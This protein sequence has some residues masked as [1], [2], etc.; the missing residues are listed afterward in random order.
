MHTLTILQGTTKY[1]VSFE[2]TPTVQQVLEANG[3]TMPH[4]C[5]GAGRCGKCEIEIIGAVSAPDEKEL[6]FDCRLSCRTR[7]YGDAT[8]ILHTDTNL[9]TESSTENISKATVSIDAAAKLGAAVDIGTTT[10]A[11]SVYDLA[12]GI[13]LASETMLNPQ[14]TVAADVIGRID[15]AAKGRLTELQNMVLSCIKTLAGRTGYIDRIDKWCITGNTTMLY[16]LQGENP[17]KLAVSP[18]VAEHL[19]GEEVPFFKKTAYLPDCMHAFVGADITCAVLASGMCDKAETALLCDVGT[20]GEIA[21]RKNEKLYTTSTAAGPVFEGAGISHGC[22][23]ITGAIETVRLKENSLSVKTIGNAKAVGLCGSGVIDTV[24]CLL[25]NGTIDETGAMEEDEILLCENVS[26]TQG[27][28]RNVQLAKAAIAAGIRTLLELTNTGAEEIST[29][30]L[31][32]GF[33]THL[34]L[35]SAVR[36]GLFPAEFRN[37]VKILGNAAL[38][39][40]ASMLTDRELK[41]KAH[42]IARNAECINLGGNPVFN[43][44]YID[45]MYFP[46]QT[47][48][49]LL[50][51]LA[52]EIEFSHIG[53]FDVAKLVFRQEVRDMCKAGRCGAYGTRWTCPPYCGALEES[54]EKAKKFSHGILLQMTG[55]MEDDF[56]VECMQETERLLK[57]RLALFAKSLKNRTISCLPMTAGTCTKCKTCTCPDAPCR[58]PEEAY[59]SM[60]AYGLIVNDVCALADVKYNYGP[61]TITFTA[62]VLFNEN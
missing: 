33:G 14:S 39:G 32:G 41:E 16:L 62:C 51:R 47:T 36:I 57:E 61:K 4:P 7:L 45:E 10:V 37:K 26:F 8:V 15:A 22:Q 13:C 20:N 58:F 52:S 31:A 53:F 5:G 3:I 11:L 40:A 24:S 54:V 42:T 46:E 9:V 17:E 34:N 49:L 44:Y 60:E 35:N 56:D 25:E 21:L 30:Y 2:G 55:A 23:S 19:F 28:I 27:D 18:F 29:F 50:L 43:Q 12:T 6:E 48:A 38:K 59:T 1:Q